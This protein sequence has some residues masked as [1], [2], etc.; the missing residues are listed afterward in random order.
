MIR[1]AAVLS[2]VLCPLLTGCSM[3]PPLTPEAPTGPTS[4]RVA[5]SCRF[6]AVT[7][8]P[9]NLPLA[10]RFGWGDGTNSDWSACVRSGMPM[11]LAHAWR[12]QGRYPVTVEAR[13]AAGRVS[14]VSGPLL[15]DI[16]GQAGYPDSVL[17]TIAVGGDPTDIAVLPAGD[18][19][20]VGN[21]LADYVTVVGTRSRSVVAR[22][23]CGRSPWLLAPSPDGRHV[24]VVNQSDGSVSVIRTSDN[25]VVATVAN[26]GSSPARCCF[27][28]DGALCYVTDQNGNKVTVIR[29][30]DNTVVARV[31]VSGTPRD[32]DCL[33]SGQYLYTANINGGVTVVRTSD[34]TVVANV[35]PGFRP[36][37]VRALPGG[38]YVY[39]AEYHGSR[40]AA[41][42]TR[43]NTVVAAFDVGVPVCGMTTVNDGE[44]LYVASNWNG[45]GAAIIRTAD[46]A[47]V[48][49]VR[50]GNSPL[51]VHSPTSGAFVASCDRGPRTVT[52]MGRRDTK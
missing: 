22:V 40:M 23:N 46:N 13:N 18:F 48:G 30:S 20:Y 38:E 25:T 52:V 9:Q 19:S 43:D 16:R 10:Y 31:A 44:Y 45:G 8:D 6:T 26:V 2:S 29:T 1:R 17:A 34:N 51:S 39:A 14:E 41:I 27:S 5:E 28:P 21:E 49:F 36:H 33:P 47:L 37:R 11:A 4:G 35:N 12:E 7:T 15:V 3:L 50:T 42:R 24:Y 32:V